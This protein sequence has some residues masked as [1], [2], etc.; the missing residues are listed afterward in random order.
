LAQVKLAHEQRMKTTAAYQFLLEDIQ[1]IKE[2]KD[3]K[4]FTLNEEKYKAE[5]A[6][7]E[8]KKKNREA[9]KAKLKESKKEEGNLILD[10][11]VDILVE[12]LPISTK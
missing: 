7:G 4:Y 8:Q 5:Q 2:S 1:N 11:A 3:R 12:N 9:Q 10:E 6:I